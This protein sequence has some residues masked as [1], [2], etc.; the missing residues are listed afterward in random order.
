MNRLITLFVLSGFLLLTSCDHTVEMITTLNEDGSLIK[1]IELKKAS[2]EQITHNYFGISP[3]TGWD[4]EATTTGEKR[5]QSDI[6][7]TREFASVDEFNQAFNLPSDTTFHMNAEFSR[8]FRWFF[9][10]IT[11]RETFEAA[12]RFEQIRQEDYFTPEEYAFIA[13]LPAEGGAVSMADSLFAAQLHKKI[14]DVYAMRGIYEDHFAF[15]E[16]GIGKYNLPSFWG[17]TLR[18][19]KEDIFSK[20][21]SKDGEDYDDDVML[22]FMDSLGIPF[23][24][25]EIDNDYHREMKRL[26]GKLNFMSWM[27]DGTF[28][29]HIEVPWNIVA[30]NADSIAGNRLTWNPPTVKYLLQ[31]FQMEVTTRKLNTW[32]LVITALSLLVLGFI[33]FRFR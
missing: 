8:D 31:D 11:Y 6:R 18:A 15:F 29:N 3:E 13:R 10:Y 25:P 33:L 30:S 4:Y 24:H 5:D 22:S 21:I 23:P 17:D 27:A 32:T 26:D 14:L 2:Q 7:F 12:D 16:N 20:L 1:T 19:Q 9:T 28:I